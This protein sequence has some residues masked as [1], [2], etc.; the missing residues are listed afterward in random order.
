ML[1]PG[2]GGQ[3]QYAGT[4]TLVESLLLIV[5]FLQYE[6]HILYRP[7]ESNNFLRKPELG[8]PT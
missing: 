2:S 8:R 4:I 5:L 1:L 6:P 7:T 3:A